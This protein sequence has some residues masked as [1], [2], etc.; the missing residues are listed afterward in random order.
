MKTEHAADKAQGEWT[1]ERVMSI[2]GISQTTW[3]PDGSLDDLCEQIN[4]SIAS[5]REK[6]ETLTDALKRMPEIAYEAIINGAGVTVENLPN[7]LQCMVDAAL[8]K[9]KAYPL[10]DGRTK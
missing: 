9:V 8:A 3:L 1:P 5:E 4:A 6:V 7:E 2:I 10:P